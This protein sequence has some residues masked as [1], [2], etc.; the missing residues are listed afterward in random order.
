[1]A[2]NQSHRDAINEAASLVRMESDTMLRS[3]VRVLNELIA[4]HPDNT[5][6]ARAMLDMVMLEIE[7]REALKGVAR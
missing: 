3:E 6:L 7:R 4:K 2:N 5:I 1:M